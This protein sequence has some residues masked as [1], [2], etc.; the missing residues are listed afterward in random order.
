[1]SQIEQE[2]LMS[3]DCGDNREV[4]LASAVGTE[5]TFNF[6]SSNTS[7]D[8][9][10]TEKYFN[11]ISRPIRHAVIRPSATILITK[12]TDNTGIETTFTDPITVVTNTAI[13]EE[14][15]GLIQTITFKVQT[16]PTNL[17]L[18]VV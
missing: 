3:N 15:F 8:D 14:R 7:A 2:Y 16:N 6:C 1:M 13:V 10:E 11:N 12:M 5:V 17:K 9:T 4:N 18:R